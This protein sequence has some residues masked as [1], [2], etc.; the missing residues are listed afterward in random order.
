MR[1]Y[2]DVEEWTKQV[3]SD[4]GMSDVAVYPGPELPDIPGRYVVWTRYGGPGIEVDGVFD[5]RSWQARVVGRS[6][7]YN[8]AEDVADVIDEAI[9]S[10][11]SHVKIGGRAVPQLQRVGGAP[12][13]LLTDDADRTHFVCSYTASVELAL[14]N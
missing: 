4:A 6:H 13:P 8:S 12:S 14:P 10:H 7:D 5:D 3:L 11:M 2:A 1:K 9:L